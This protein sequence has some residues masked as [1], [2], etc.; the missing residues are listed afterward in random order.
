MASVLLRKKDIGKFVFV[1]F[2]DHASGGELVYTEAVGWI[3]GVTSQKLVLRHWRT[4][5][6]PGWTPEDGDDAIVRG[7]IKELRELPEP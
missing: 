7:T 5:K 3:A 2:W 4:P 1:G 6:H